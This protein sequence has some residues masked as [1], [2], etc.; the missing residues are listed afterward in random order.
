VAEEM[1]SV[2]LK[3]KIMQSAASFNTWNGERILYS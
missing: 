2:K 3:Y 1:S